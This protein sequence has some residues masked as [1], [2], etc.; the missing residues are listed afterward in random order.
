MDEEDLREQE[1]SKQISTADGFVGFG[2]QDDQAV[3]HALDDIFK[4]VQD[5][6]GEKLLNRMG[7]K[8]GQGI[9]ARIRRKIDPNDDASEVKEYP[10]ADSPMLDFAQEQDKRGLSSDDNAALKERKAC[11]VNTS[12][13]AQESMEQENHT[14]IRFP[15][16]LSAKTNRPVKSSGIGIGSLND[17]RSD[18]EDLYE[19]GPKMNYNRVLGGEKK[20]KK[21]KKS[22]TSANPLLKSTPKF[23]SKKLPSILSSLRKCH[24]GKLPLTGFV[25]ADPDELDGFGAMSILDEKYRPPEVPESWQPQASTETSSSSNVDGQTKTSQPELVHQQQTAQSRANILKEASLPSKSIFDYLSPAARDRLA[26]ASGKTD[27]PPALNEAPPPTAGRTV[28]VTPDAAPQ[29]AYPELTATTA[30][31][32]MIR[33]RKDKDKPYADDLPKQ[34]RYKDFLRFSSE[35]KPLA[36]RIPP[37]RAPT[38]KTDEDHLIELHE[39]A[40]TANLFRPA[41]GFLA[42]RFTSAASAAASVSDSGISTSPHQ[43]TSKDDDD[44][45]E[46]LLRKP[47]EKPKDPAEEAARLGMFGVATR[48]T[49]GFYPTKLVCKRFGVDMPTL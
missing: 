25:L 35:T 43:E 1:E 40:T 21:P 22:S 9:G 10:P 4:P 29:I 23:I 42:S 18:D 2:T 20:A 31:T 3:R 19:M 8:K 17:T 15:S 16:S 14:G 6:M 37:L 28:P 47:P 26:T 44:A 46:N 39:F 7:W 49:M 12:L 30:S 38:H 11:Q 41:T 5:S 13:V 34:G 27:L 45:E 48:S 36:E 24:D 32:A 33:L